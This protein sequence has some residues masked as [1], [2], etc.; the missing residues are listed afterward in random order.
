MNMIPFVESECF[1]SFLSY[2]SLSLSA[3][4]TS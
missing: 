2:L 3:M 4:K 1:V